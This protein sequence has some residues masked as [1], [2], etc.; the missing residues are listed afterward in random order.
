MHTLVK[1]H[2]DGF[3]CE[4]NRKFPWVIVA[5]Y[6]QKFLIV[7]ASKLELQ[8]PLQ[9]KLVLCFSFNFKNQYITYTICASPR[10]RMN[11]RMV[12]NSSLTA[13]N[14][15][16]K[17]PLNFTS[18]TFWQLGLLS[19]PSSKKMYRRYRKTRL[20]DVLAAYLYESNVECNFTVGYGQPLKAPNLE[21]FT[22]NEERPD[23]INLKVTVF[24]SV[25]LS[26]GIT[27]WVPLQQRYKPEVP[28]AGLQMFAVLET[29]TAR[30][31]VQPW[32]VRISQP[33]CTESERRVP[34]Y[35]SQD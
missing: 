24:Y 31:L 19:P 13:G 21:K 7:M 4:I 11:Y 2:R 1:S 14:V 16:R 26:I 5:S 32:R 6:C 20:Q 27:V 12:T 9:S 18:F 25:A 22:L 28:S 29:F 17:L 35:L 23:I 33:L 8:D 34:P 15:Y 30:Q 3:M 10:R